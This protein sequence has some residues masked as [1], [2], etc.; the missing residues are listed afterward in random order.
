MSM[1]SVMK[2]LK[3]YGLLF[4]SLFVFLFVLWGGHYW[5]AQGSLPVHSAPVA[6][7][8]WFC[9]SSSFQVRQNISALVG[10]TVSILP[11]LD[12]VLKDT[13]H[14]DLKQSVVSYSLFQWDTLL[15][16]TD[17]SDFVFEKVGNYEIQTT[18]VYADC[19][20]TFST[21]V[22]VY[23]DVITIV[24]NVSE[25]LL[26]P[27]RFIF[28]KEHVLLHVIPEHTDQYT[29]FL[30]EMEKLKKSEYVILVSD[31]I[32]AILQ[33]LV[34]LNKN[35]S[36]DLLEKKV[37]FVNSINKHLLKRIVSKYRNDFDAE[38]L[39][40]T[41][42]HNFL[43]LIASLSNKEDLSN[44]EYLS[45]FS[46][47]NTKS[48]WYLLLSSVVDMLIY[49]GFPITLLS[50]LLTISLAVLVVTVFRQLIGFDV[51]GAYSPLMLGVVIH[52]LWLPLTCILLGFWFLSTILVRIFTKKIYLLY[53]AKIS[54]LVSLYFLWIFV[55]LS[56][57]YSFFTVFIDFT[58]FTN[59]LVVFPMLLIIFVS[60][61]ICYEGFSFLQ[62]SW[63]IS[64]IE[65]SIV[66]ALVYSII[67]SVFIQNFMLAYPEV[68]ILVVILIV[69]V[70]R[71]SWLQLLEYI[72]FFPLIHDEDKEE[73][74]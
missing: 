33:N 56:Y 7:S 6:S 28:E 47:S 43:N 49:H 48:P 55:W 51:F 74:E 21:D 13:Y 31:S 22:Y 39:Y 53:S 57:F 25:K 69:L 18:F 34:K 8:E 5:Y 54:L 71:F 14:I 11:R 3:F 35:F 70:G 59:L 65:F 62:K 36:L 66:S 15:K 40:T 38:M 68:I 29:V 44:S 12:P 32:D 1:I 19:S 20:L 30:S 63:W 23:A 58:F 4:V 10:E 42:K 26:E 72:R 67:H 9:S 27:Y 41:N 60:E 50:L 24:G 16:K 46:L 73:E 64:F 61:K 37:I 2:Y 52:I 45:L 17:V